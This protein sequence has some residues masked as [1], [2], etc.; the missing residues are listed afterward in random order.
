MTLQIG[1][2]N[3]LRTDDRNEP[4]SIL[5]WVRFYRSRGLVVLPIERGTKRC[6][7]KGWDELAPEELE[8]MITED[9]D[10]GIRL[11]DLAVLDIERPE[12]VRALTRADAEIIAKQTWVAK[13]GKG[14]HIY[15]RG[16][17][18][19]KKTIR[20]EGLVEFRT[21][22]DFYVVAP[23]SLHPSGV[24]YEWISD[25]ELI[26]IAEA[27]EALLE[28]IYH[29]VEVLK[30]FKA[31]IEELVRIWTPSHRH[32][33]AIWLSGCLR[34]SGVDREDAET[35]LK[36]IAC[37]A[38]DEE[39][40]DRLRALEDSYRKP[41]D[42][43]GAWSYLEEELRCI[44]GPE[45]AREIMDLIPR[46]EVRT[47]G[48]VINARVDEPSK[49]KTKFTVGGERLPDGSWV[50]IVEKDG[51][52]HLLVYKD[53]ELK[54]V[55]SYEAGDA[56]YKP[57]PRLPFALPR[58]IERLEDDRALW[59]DTKAFVKEYFD[60]PDERAY[61]VIV[62]AIAWSYFYRAVA[63]LVPNASTPYLQFLGPWRSGKTRAL[64]VF[65][66]VAHRA[67]PVVD[68]SEAAIF[69]MIELFKPTLVIDEANV[70]DPNILAIMAAA[71]RKGQFVPRAD[72]ENPN[73]VHLYDVFSFIIYATREQ[74]RDDIF[75]RSVTI[76]CEK[77]LRPTAK[78]IDENKAAELRTR[79][80]AQYLRLR[81]QV[82]VTYTEYESEDGRLQELFS[83]LLVMARLFG[84]PDA[85]KN[86]E[87]YGR[88][89]EE[90]IRGL[91]TASDEAAVVEAIIKLIGERPGD[92]PEY[93]L[94]SEIA[95]AMADGEE[96]GPDPRW[97]GRIMHQLGFAKIKISG[98]KRGYKLDYDLLTR[99]SKRYNIT[100]TP[101]L[102][103][104]PKP[105]GGSPPPL[106]PERKGLF[107]S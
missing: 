106:G 93:L 64:E 63:D 29:K 100:W 45:K 25:V 36:A 7:I 38:H 10:I 26:E 88:K 52:P 32:N 81:D 82:R 48:E 35:V 39:L 3:A 61:D 59:E 43:I 8:K 41:A 56:I 33:L 70:L 87:S 89:I 31:L 74:I 57:R 67:V 60:V 22:N 49:P 6:L 86:I 66:A 15:M 5:D 17:L 104:S 97:V 101:P 47:E 23:P 13:T 91:E 16:S 24:R 27:S 46:R 95:K 80:F 51:R 1:E 40:E 2:R 85:E 79:W 37:L 73:E 12:L 90:R 42:Q 55:E 83:P 92:A 78:L 68:P 72:R 44:V 30:E 98:G 19:G 50:E 77:A 96:N 20:A 94:T 69:R 53:G 34:K 14:Y 65:R 11:D 75:S 62:A 102:T 103:L 105:E 54:I 58:V 71:Y 4:R 99:L 21:G 18:S 107:S 28:R 9:H 84:N 76:Y